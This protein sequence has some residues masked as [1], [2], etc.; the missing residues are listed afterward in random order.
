MDSDRT[1]RWKALCKQ[2]E[3]EV[4]PARL[5]ELVDEID[6]LL[7]AEGAWLRGRAQGDNG[8]GKGGQQQDVDG[9]DGS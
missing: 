3:S 5:L 9:S 8:V 1:Q 7:E 6:R 2:A 4:D